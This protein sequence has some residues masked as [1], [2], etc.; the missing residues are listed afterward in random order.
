MNVINSNKKKILVISTNVE[1]QSKLW[2][3]IFRNEGLLFDAEKV[4]LM[5][6]RWIQNQQKRKPL[7][8]L[9]GCRWLCMFFFSILFSFWGCRKQSPWSVI[10][11]AEWWFT[12]STLYC[13]HYYL[14]LSHTKKLINRPYQ[15]VISI[16][17]KQ[18]TSIS[19]R[20]GKCISRHYL[21]CRMLCFVDKRLM[22]TQHVPIFKWAII[23]Y[24]SLYTVQASRHPF[25]SVQHDIRFGISFFFILLLFARKELFETFIHFARIYT[26]CLLLSFV[27]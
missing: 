7:H 11:I 4:H 17:A 15:F 13:Y 2:V 19:Q 5:K 22:S 26:R 12:N 16:R 8:S 23:Q 9:L 10:S 25:L 18:M 6:F 21:V 24:S 14:H 3:V 27:F 1:H 20:I